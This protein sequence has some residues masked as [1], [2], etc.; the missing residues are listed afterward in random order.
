[1]LLGFFILYKFFS[2]L[3]LPKKIRVISQKIKM[4]DKKI[5]E[6]LNKD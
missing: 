1:M 4:I 5:V 2:L 3:K 6:E